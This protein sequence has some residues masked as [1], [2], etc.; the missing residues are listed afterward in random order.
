MARADRGAKGGEGVIGTIVV[1]ARMG[2][3]FTRP[4]P[5]S[6]AAAFKGGSKAR[7][8]PQL[9][10][11]VS[12]IDI[13]LSTRPFASHYNL[14]HT[15]RPDIPGDALPEGSGEPR[16]RI[17]EEHPDHSVIS[18]GVTSHRRRHYCCASLSALSETLGAVWGWLG[19]IAREAPTSLP[20]RPTL[21]RGKC[22]SAF[23][24]SSNVG[25]P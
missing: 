18:F 11:G 10:R 3:L 16:K 22:F 14:K 1:P 5:A 6:S 2:V 8:P 7:C 25:A 21:Y 19:L 15:R 17:G 24:M 13:K 23:A 9:L 20:F 12:P 4:S